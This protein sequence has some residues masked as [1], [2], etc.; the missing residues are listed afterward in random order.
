MK[1][2]ITLLVL[3]VAVSGFAQTIRATCEN[4]HYATGYVKLHQYRV[5]VDY[6]KVSQ[7]ASYTLDNVLVQSELFSITDE[8]KTANDLVIYTIKENTTDDLTYDIEGINDID[9]VTVSCKYDI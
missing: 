6:K 3:L 9:G 7:D 4:A 1:K 8:K 5:L 2:I